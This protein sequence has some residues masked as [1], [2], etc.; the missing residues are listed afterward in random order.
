M[1]NS[2]KLPSAKEDLLEI[3]RKHQVDDDTLDNLDELFASEAVDALVEVEKSPEPAR[4]SPARVKKES[5]KKELDL[6]WEAEEFRR[7]GERLQTGLLSIQ[8]AKK[9][10]ERLEDRISQT[11]A[12]TTHGHAS[13]VKVADCPLCK[14]QEPKATVTY[15]HLALPRLFY[16]Q[17]RFRLSL[18][19]TLLCLLLAWFCAESTMCSYYCRPEACGPGEDCTWSPDDPFFGY[20]LPVKLDQW[21]TGGSGRVLVNKL[22]EEVGD[23]A[24]NAWAA[25]KGI[26]MA[27][28]DTLS[29]DFEQRR[30]HRRRLRK[31]GLVKAWTPPAE[32]KATM[33][34][35]AQATKERERAYALRDMGY[36][37]GDGLGSESMEG[38]KKVSS[39]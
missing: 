13:G 20:A 36:D 10:I 26:D 21:A 7:M 18:L 5:V 9:G 27:A 34:A 2:F 16:R 31:R 39:R 37:I 8:T 3:Q 32:H 33:D 12:K 6:E 24:A 15:V 4:A 35:W 19:G 1:V 11:E 30:R 38:D 28:V 14:D 25:I 23:L 29:M 17:P 22:S